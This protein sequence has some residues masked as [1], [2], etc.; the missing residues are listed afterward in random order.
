[1]ITYDTGSNRFIINAPSWEIGPV[2]RLPIRRFL[3]RTGVWVAPVTRNNAQHMLD[4]MQ[5]WDWEP[6][7]REVAQKAATVE[8]ETRP[9]PQWY[10]FKTTPMDHQKVACERAYSLDSFYLAME[11]GTGKTFVVINTMCAHRLH[12]R[13][14]RAVIVAPNCVI[15]TW[16][17]EIQK[18]CGLPHR[19]WRMADDPNPLTMIVDE[20]QIGF[21]LV[22]AESLSQGRATEKLLSWTPAWKFGMY[23]DE[24]HYIKT[25]GKVRTDA[26]IAIGR[27]AK[28]RLAGS[29]TQITKSLVDLY[30]QYEYLDTNIIGIGDYYAFRNRYCIMGGFKRKEIIGYDNTDELMGFVRPHTYS[31]LKKDCLDLPPKVYERRYVDLSTAHMALYKALRKNSLKPYQLPNVLVKT[32]RL[33]QLLSGLLPTPESARAHQEDPT[34]REVTYQAVKITAKIEA[35]AADLDALEGSVLI[36]CQWRADI[37]Q[38]CSLL[39]AGTYVVLHGDIDPD[40][41]QVRINKFQTGRVRYFVSTIDAG[42]IGITLTAASTVCFLSHTDN[43]AKRMQAEDRAHRIG[44]KH[45][46]TYIDYYANNTVDEALLAAHEAKVDLAEFL[47]VRMRTLP[48]EKLEELL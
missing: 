21:V 31:I 20:H 19:V 7:A 25:P 37:G 32:L 15:R 10:Q 9:W 47:K 48:A 38:I 14:D 17:E 11:Q 13:I 3:K 40:E 28:V 29:G 2:M 12:Q 23:V 27:N 34:V 42:G 30:S 1:M 39:N 45:T 5:A 44:T 43:Y 26:A 36:F 24:A 6:T 4:T 41:R 46:V 18:H 8:H 16:E 22:S 35:L 33:R